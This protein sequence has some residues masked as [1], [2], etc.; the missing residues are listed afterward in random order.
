[1]TYLCRLVDQVRRPFCP[2]NGALVQLPLNLIVADDQGTF[3]K[4]AVSSDLQV[5]CREFQLRFPAMTLVTGWDDDLGFQEFSR[6]M[7]SDKRRLNRFGKGFGIGDPPLKDQLAALCM[8]A[9]RAFEHFIY[10]LFRKQDALSKPGNR[11]LYS[12]L[13]KVRRYLYPRLD[14]IVADGMGVEDGQNTLAPLN[15]GCYFA[16]G[17][18][19][20][21]TRAFVIKAFERLIET[22]EDLE[23][24]AAA[25]R[26]N[27]RYYTLAYASLV[28]SGVLLGLSILIACLPRILQ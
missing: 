20:E 9:C 25:E 5:L 23:W 16:A 19:H 1:L 7:G 21:D 12:L 14:R 18:A 15:A 3:T 27:Q 22:S 26:S 11:A 6:R 13:C 2:I 4:E 24:T 17:S 8:H 10:E 28:A